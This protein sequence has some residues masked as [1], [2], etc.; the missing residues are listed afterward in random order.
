VALLTKWQLEGDRLVVRLDANEDIYRKSIG[1]ALT[2]PSGLNMSEV[3][4]TF[5][6]EKLGATYF[7]GFRPID[8][9]WATQDLT[10]TGA[11]VMPA[12]FGVGD[13]RLFV[14][15]IQMASVIGNNTPKI[16]RAASRR[17]NNKMPHVAEKYNRELERLIVE[18]RLNSRMVE[19]ANHPDTETVR[20]GMNAIDGEG[21]Q[22]MK[23]CEKNAGR[24]SLEE[25]PFPPNRQF[26]YG[27]SKCMSHCCVTR[28][29]KSEIEATYGGLLN[30]VVS[31]DHCS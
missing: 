27:G 9:I 21:K 11:C 4:G 18:H 14:V 17:L 3:V 12:G 24:S 7:R 19:V 6:G 1:K 16:V 29:A 25:S 10:I 5:T 28:R 2:D 8:G 20:R 23:H 31:R 26:G 22:Y 13:H 30:G 15:D